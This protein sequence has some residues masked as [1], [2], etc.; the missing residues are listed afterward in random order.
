MSAAP[1]VLVLEDEPLI[2]M[3]VQGWLEELGCETV[4][5]A[6]S[7]PTAL[8][9][10]ANGSLDGAIL[11]VSIGSGDSTAVA[12]ALRQKGVPYALA[13]GR[14]GGK[15]VAEYGK[16]PS[17]LKPYDFADVRGVMAQILG[18]HSGA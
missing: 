8:D 5:P 4:G 17:L 14:A 15:L 12:D 11:D 2:A 18:P 9:L 16:A 6:H 7:V 13:T 10:I 1:R 3:M